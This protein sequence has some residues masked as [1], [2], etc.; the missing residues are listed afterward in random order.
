MAFSLIDPELDVNR[1]R[2]KVIIILNSIAPDLKE[3]DQ[4]EDSD[5][6]NPTGQELIDQTQDQIWKLIA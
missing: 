3:L 2:P 5:S 4:S 6:D 1:P